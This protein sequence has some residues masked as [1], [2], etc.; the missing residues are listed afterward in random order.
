MSEI[1][2]SDLLAL[3][4]EASEMQS[5]EPAI[6]DSVEAHLSLAAELEQLD[7]FEGASV[8]YH[9]ATL[10]ADEVSVFNAYG[11][12]LLRRGQFTEAID[13][14]RK[15][16]AVDPN[17]YDSGLS[18]SSLA[19]HAGDEREAEGRLLQVLRCHPHHLEGD[20]EPQKP[21]L[22]RLRG[23]E[24][25]AYGIVQYLDGS[26]GRILRGGHFSTDHLLNHETYNIR[27]LNLFKDNL[28]QNEP[29]PPF[30]LFLN[31]IACPDS[32]QESL[33]TATQLLRHYPNVPII[34]HPKLVLET[35]RER[36]SIR[37][38]TIEGVK[39]PKTNQFW[40]DGV[41]LE[42]LVTDIVDA[43]FEFPMIVR[44]VGTQTG[45]TVALIEDRVWLRRHFEM[46]PPHRSYYMIQFEDCS[47]S[48]SVFH[49]MRIFFIDGVLYPVANVFHDAW[50]IHSGDRYSVMD[51]QE[52][53]QEEE[54]RFLS[55]PCSYLGS[56]NIE[57]LYA[58]RDLIQL[59][60][61]GI[62]FTILQT[63]VLFIFELNAA[64]R[65]NYDH[66]G[67]FPY[68]KSYLEKISNAFDRM[69]RS[70]LSI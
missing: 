60:F 62:D 55:D 19:H 61:F 59:D 25:S 24:G 50:N 32:K 42:S 4:A 9:R 18:L 2:V 66:A 53:M 17:D 54:K 23:F 33:Q 44:E 12:F 1:K 39:F 65:H 26:Y 34:N 6:P 40:W 10:L 15:S 45:E 16:V 70:R 43:G 20:F 48:S 21:T 37:L 13:L 52:W 22:L 5:T 38:N 51:Q 8:H 47:I 3:N 7:R 57:K 30:D 31:T 29:L 46:S 35:T 36:N 28:E 14:F 49:K 11:S 41:A 67:N 68:T 69:V 27:V 63:G 56:D 58:V 64:M